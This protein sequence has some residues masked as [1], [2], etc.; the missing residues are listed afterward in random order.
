[1]ILSTKPFF[2]KS[3]IKFYIMKVV[4]LSAM[5]CISITCQIHAQEPKFEN[6]AM[7]R[8][9]QKDKAFAE[10]KRISFNQSTWIG[11]K[12]PDLIASWGN[13]TKS[14]KS[15]SGSTVILYERNSIYSSGNYTPGYKVVNAANPNQVYEEHEA[16]DTR[17]TTTDYS[18]L[19]V[20][21]DK[22]NIITKIDFVRDTKD[23]P[24]Q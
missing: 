7:Q 20:H 4:L 9:Y 22:N 2:L 15:E 11:A 3:T 13:P 6:A 21:A 16:I 1:M 24:K 14:Y 10:S 23:Y 5:M 19:R 12:L 8:R 17:V 18:A